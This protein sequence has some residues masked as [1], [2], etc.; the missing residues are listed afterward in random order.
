MKK[1]VLSAGRQNA[2]WQGKNPL[3]LSEG[4]ARLLWHLCY[5]IDP[6]LQ[7]SPLN[8]QLRVERSSGTFE[9]EKLSFRMILGRFQGNDFFCYTA[10]KSGLFYFLN[11]A[12]PH[13]E[14]HYRVFG[15]GDKVL[16]LGAFKGYSCQTISSALTIDDLGDDTKFL[17]D[18]IV[19]IDSENHVLNQAAQQAMDV[20]REQER[21][22]VPRPST[23]ERADV[24]LL[25]FIGLFCV[26][27]VLAI[28][29]I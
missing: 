23:K 20:S 5:A 17:E 26:L 6:L 18:L 15:L 4:K 9:N 22:S 2:A 14:K 25:L 12:R 21:N 16:L 3:Y 28:G 7:C 1:R 11:G 27:V 10:S 24:V 29:L 8:L 19:S 13:E